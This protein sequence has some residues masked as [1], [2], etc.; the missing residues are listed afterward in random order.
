MSVTGAQLVIQAR[1]LGYDSSSVEQ[2]RSNRWLLTLRTPDGTTLLVLAQRRPL[3]LAADVHDLIDLLRLRRI[4]TGFL[5]AVEGRFSAEALRIA[6]DLRS[7]RLQLGTDL[8][9]A[10]RN[11]P[12]GSLETA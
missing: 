11:A 1:A 5:L 10:F 6:Q 2:L 4:N 7:L 8:P 3:I 12:S 9:P